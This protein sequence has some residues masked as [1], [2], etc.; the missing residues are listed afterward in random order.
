MI[1]KLDL[2]KYYSK[3]NIDRFYKKY[4]H[5]GYSIL[6]KNGHYLMC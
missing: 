5:S 6:C 1:F 3:Y 4:I 2:N